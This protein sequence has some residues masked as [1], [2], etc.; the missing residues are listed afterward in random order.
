MMYRFTRIAVK[1]GSNVLTHSDGTLDTE[2]M[3]GLVEQL[4]LLHSKGVEIVLISSGAVASGRTTLKLE[5]EPDPVSARQIF[6]AIGQAR[7]INIYYELFAKHGICCGQV[8]TTKESLSTRS[9]YLNQKNCITGLLQNKVIP[10]LNENDTISLTELMFTDNDE[11]SGLVATMMD[12][13]ALII[14]SNIDGIYNSNPSDPDAKVITEVAEGQ[15]ITKYIQT[16]KSSF[17]RGG[18]MTKTNIA[19]KVA[20]EGITVIIANGKKENI[21]PDLLEKDSKIVCTTFLP[22]E[23]EVSSIKKWIA[24][25]DGFSKGSITINE[26]ACKALLSE[27]ASSI[28]FVGITKVEGEFLKGDIIKIKDIAG[29]VVAVGKAQYDNVKMTQSIG[30]RG[31]RPAVLYDYLWIN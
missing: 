1:I 8:L 3:S 19:R 15:N 24:H 14:L 2:R 22:S 30:K 9:H 6:S 5:K 21:L 4:S 18:M 20:A 17:G 26:N 31:L 13:E 10:I 27:K 16:S 28:L 7:L 11:L 12:V 25:S 23:K 29:K